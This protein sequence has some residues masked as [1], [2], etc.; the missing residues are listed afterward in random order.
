MQT[1]CESGRRNSRALENNDV[2]YTWKLPS[3]GDLAQVVGQLPSR[4]DLQHHPPKKEEWKLPKKYIL[5]VFTIEKIKYVK[6]WTVY[7]DRFDSVC[8]VY[9]YQNITL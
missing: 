3:A 8:N 9:I 7:L 6:R 4:R 5:H 1:F 2:L